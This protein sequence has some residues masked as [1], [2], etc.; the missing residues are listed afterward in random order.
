MIRQRK[1][2]GLYDVEMANCSR[3]E[4]LKWAENIANDPRKE[5]RKASFE[6]A[7]CFYSQR[8]GGCAMTQANC[9]GCGKVTTFPSTNTD[10]LCSSCA[11]ALKLC[12]HCGADM[13]LKGRRNIHSLLDGITWQE[14]DNA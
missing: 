13:E 9:R 1:R 5:E 8:I 3:K 7:P 4:V 6:C 14:P 11:A 10:E 2:I 12:K